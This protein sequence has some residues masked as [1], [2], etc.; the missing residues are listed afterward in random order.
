[1][2]TAEEREIDLPKELR[3][4]RKVKHRYIIRVM[5]IF[6]HRGHVYIFM[7]RAEGGDLA[8][9]RFTHFPLAER[10]VSAWFLQLME[11]ISYLHQIMAIAHRDV[12]L[13]NL[14]LDVRHNLKLCD[15]G[16]SFFGDRKLGSPDEQPRSTDIL[17]TRPCMCPQLLEGVSYNPY[18]ADIFAIGASLF[19]MLAEGYPYDRT[20][21]DNSVLLEQQTQ[22]YPQFLRS[23]FVAVVCLHL[24]LNIF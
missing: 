24:F 9:Y 20:I 7:E 12:K 3:A 14:L 1:M 8:T 22:N 13:G 19:L 10:L 11:A 23:R 4:L 6:R 17:G 5:D 15:F 2:L 16:F 21:K 18:K